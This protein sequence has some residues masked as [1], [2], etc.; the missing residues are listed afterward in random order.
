M[1]NRTTAAIVNPRVSLNHPYAL[2]C[3][4]L[5]YLIETL[6]TF[7]TIFS[8]LAMRATTARACAVDILRNRP[9][10]DHVWFEDRWMVASLCDE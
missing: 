1:C 5:V 3:S 4:T 7:D 8:P 6:L 2:I 10:E 9:S